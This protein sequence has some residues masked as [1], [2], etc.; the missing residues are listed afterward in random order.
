MCIVDIQANEPPDQASCNKARCSWLAKVNP[1]MGFERATRRT[2]NQPLFTVP[3]T[4]PP[5]LGSSRLALSPPNKEKEEKGVTEDLCCCPCNHLPRK[6]KKKEK[7]TDLVTNFKIR[8]CV[9]IPLYT[10]CP[11]VSCRLGANT[12]SWAFVP[13]TLGLSSSIMV[14]QDYFLKQNWGL[15]RGGRFPLSPQCLSCTGELSEV[16]EREMKI[17]CKG[18]KLFSSYSS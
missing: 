18:E 16:T 8:G 7:R 3:R 2:L 17:Q 6:K 15:G 5:K 9:Q 14:C 12:R 13:V 1:L 11:F 4:L 10:H